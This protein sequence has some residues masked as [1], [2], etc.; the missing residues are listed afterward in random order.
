MHDRFLKR[1]KIFIVE[2]PVP[3]GSLGSNAGRGRRCERI[4][5]AC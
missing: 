4:W 5:L 1:N 3:I 2:I